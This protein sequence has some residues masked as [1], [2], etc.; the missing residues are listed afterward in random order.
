MVNNLLGTNISSVGTRHGIQS[1]SESGNGTEE[2][3]IH[4]QSSS[5][6]RWLD[7][8]GILV[9]GFNPFE[10]YARQNGNLPQIGVKIKNIWNH[11]LGI[12]QNAKIQIFFFVIGCFP[13]S[14]EV[15]LWRFQMSN[16]QN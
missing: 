7:P 3:I 6:V 11:H 14:K 5:D 13:L 10:K 9:G 16:V 2:V 12:F 4:P 1:P 15:I 8:L